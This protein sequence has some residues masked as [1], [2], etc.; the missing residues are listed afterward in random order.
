MACAGRVGRGARVAPLPS[1]SPSLLPRFGQA[2]QHHDHLHLRGRVEAGS[3]G[4]HRAWPIPARVDRIPLTAGRALFVGDAAAATD[5]MT[6]E[7]I[8]QAL[9]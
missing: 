8:G 5:P 2:Q 1:P 4:P 6:G 9:E 3:P 7:G